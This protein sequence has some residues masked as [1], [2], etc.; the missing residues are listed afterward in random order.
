MVAPGLCRGTIG[1]AL[2]RLSL[3]LYNEGHVRLWS[4]RRTDGDTPPDHASF[5]GPHPKE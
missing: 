1:M 5:M 2:H 4:Y 3:Y